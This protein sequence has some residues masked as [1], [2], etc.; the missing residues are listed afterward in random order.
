[1][2]RRVAV[3]VDGTRVVQGEWWIWSVSISGI[4]RAEAFWEGPQLLTVQ[5]N[6][7][8]EAAALPDTFGE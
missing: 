5:E 1:M 3:R 2:L 7:C 4:D 8:H 6:E